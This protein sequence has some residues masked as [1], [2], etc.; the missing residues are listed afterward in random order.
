MAAGLFASL[1]VSFAWIFLQIGFM[2][3][4]P[5][6]N[7]IRSMTLFFAAS[8]PF[9]FLLLRPGLIPKFIT[10]ASPGGNTAMQFL[11]AYF[12]HLLIFFLFVECFYH[13][14]RAVTL[15]FLIEIMRQPGGIARLGEITKDYNVRDMIARRLEALESHNFISRSGDVWR[16]KPK[17]RFFARAMQFSCWIF[18]SKGQSERL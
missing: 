7:R 13:V 15:R 9:V 5:A 4:R 10:E 1:V 11:H 17:G 6:E 18:Q 2:H 3:V 16:L 14:E 12:F 8:L